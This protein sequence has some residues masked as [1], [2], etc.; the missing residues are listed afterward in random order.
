MLR[1]HKLNNR[2]IENTY[3]MLKYLY[4]EMNSKRFGAVEI[5]KCNNLLEL[6][7]LVISNW[8]LSIAKEGL[9]KEYINIEGKEMTSP[10]GQIDIQ[11]TINRQTKI[12]GSIVCNYDELNDD[13]YI[14][15]V[16]KSILYEIN[17]EDVNEYVRKYI[18]KTLQR[19]NGITVRELK[20][21]RLGSI[22]YTNSNI[23]YKN[24]I[25]FCRSTL[26]ENRI[27]ASDEDRG[28][29]VFKKQ[30]IKYIAS[31]YPDLII[32]SFQSEID[33]DIIDKRVLKIDNI[34]VIRDEEKAIL[35]SVRLQDKDVK[36]DAKDIRNKQEY[37]LRLAKQYYNENKLKTTGAIVYA[38]M[39]IRK[40]NIEP[41]TTTVYDGFMIIET[42]VDV[43]DHW[44]YIESKIAALVKVMN[45][46]GG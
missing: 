6:Y 36:V 44:R 26:E 30:L 43:F 39:D 37:I 24:L 2:V 42:V 20:Y 3:K 10:I 41:L 18:K 1:K 27:N 14:N 32:N 19:F 8:A 13:I 40:I 16:V 23:R 5:D 34:I 33:D 31:M 25:N 21:E 15:Q 4:V 29:I 17:K 46:K 35:I 45:F 11:E 38:N 22:K 9:Y 12:R 7:A 28:Y